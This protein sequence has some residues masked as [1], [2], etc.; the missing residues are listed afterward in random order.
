M[1]PV[2]I[3]FSDDSTEGTEVAFGVVRPVF[4]PWWRLPMR[5][6][7]LVTMY[8]VV[9]LWPVF[10]VDSFDEWMLW[11]F[12]AQYSLAAMLGFLGSR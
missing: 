3:Q 9:M 7:W 5:I 2:A 1:Q 12:A 4:L 11:I 8:V 10:L 6:R